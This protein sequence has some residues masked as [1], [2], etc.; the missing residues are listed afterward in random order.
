MIQRNYTTISDPTQRMKN[1]NNIISSLFELIY[2]SHSQ[3]E[4]I[5]NNN[6]ISRWIYGLPK[7]HKKEIPLRLHV[8]FINPVTYGVSKTYLMLQKWF[9]LKN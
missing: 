7:I 6:A 8:S 2:I 3:C 1:I 9:E 5:Y 4:N